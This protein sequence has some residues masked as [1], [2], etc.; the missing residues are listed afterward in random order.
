MRSYS[1][2]LFEPASFAASLAAFFATDCYG[3]DRD[4]TMRSNNGMAR[5]VIG[6]ACA[7]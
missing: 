1:V 2:G 6:D 3:A 4:A 7:F 5:F